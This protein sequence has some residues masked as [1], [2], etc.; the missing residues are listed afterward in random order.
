M[1]YP[2]LAHSNFGEIIKHSGN[3]HM[4]HF[5]STIALSDQNMTALEGNHKITTNQ[6]SATKIGFT[7]SS[8]HM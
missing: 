2:K 1:S 3:A 5:Q 6:A 8:L 7:I 4:H